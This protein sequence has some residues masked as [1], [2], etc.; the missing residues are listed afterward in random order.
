MNAGGKCWEVSQKVKNSASCVWGSE[1]KSDRILFF[2]FA[3]S[4]TQIQ[5]QLR[6]GINLTNKEFITKPQRCSSV[7]QRQETPQ[8]EAATDLIV[9]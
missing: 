8:K 6:R 4:K 2:I 5:Q 1:Q 7:K 9:P 3:G